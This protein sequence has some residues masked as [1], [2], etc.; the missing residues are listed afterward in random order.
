MKNL[1]IGSIVRGVRFEDDGILS[2]YYSS[3]MEQF[4]GEIG[5]IIG[6]GKGVATDQFA[7]YGGSW[8]YPLNELT[9]VKPEK[10]YIVERSSLKYLGDNLQ[11]VGLQEILTSQVC[12]EKITLTDIDKYY[13]T[14]SWENEPIAKKW[15]DTYL[16]DEPN[17]FNND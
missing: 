5:V 9:E 7:K 2:F 6:I 11:H 1:K 15:L 10:F 16:S 4:V 3:E 13:F 17:L 8:S 12:E 14:I